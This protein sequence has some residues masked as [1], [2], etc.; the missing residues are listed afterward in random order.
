[1]INP[2]VSV[3]LVIFNGEK[4][5]RHC[6]DSVVKQTYINIEVNILDNNSTDKTRQII[7]EYLIKK[8]KYKFHVSN[9]NLGMW[10]G[11]EKLFEHS[12][13]KYIVVLSVD[14]ILSPNFIEQAIRVFEDDNN[15]GA[16]QGKIYQWQLIQKVPKLSKIIDTIGFKISRSRRLVNIAQGDKD[17]EEFNHE[18]EILAAEGAVPIFRRR[19]LEDCRLET[20]DGKITDPDFFWYGDDLDLTWRMRIFGWKQLYSPRVIAYHD[21]STTK[22]IKK[23]WYDYFSRIKNRKQIPIKK[24]RLDWTNYRLALIKND[25]NIFRDLPYILVR[26]IMVLGYTLLFEPGVFLGFPRFFRLLPKTLKRRKEIMTKAK[27]S[28]KEMHE[29]FT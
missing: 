27:V 28:A 15:I 19:A 16:I 23:H 8:P 29:W 21:R 4:Y 26:E 25:Q 10:P 22:D 18:K 6:L 11:Q 7:Q 12:N 14:V 5:I 13:G 1:M 24:R 3:N 17:M 9:S 2:P 20:Q